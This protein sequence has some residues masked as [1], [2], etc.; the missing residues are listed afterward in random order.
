MAT[1]RVLI[2]DDDTWL[3]DEFVRLLARHG[4]AAQHVSNGLAGMDAI[5]LERPDVIVLDL[6][7][8]GPNGLVLL[9]ELQTHSDLATIPII[10]CSNSSADVSLETLRPYGVH[11]MLDKTSMVPADLVSAIRKVLP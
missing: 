1:S 7:M 10:L 4:F 5:D 6:F 11:V 9:H 2:I 8:P 3:G